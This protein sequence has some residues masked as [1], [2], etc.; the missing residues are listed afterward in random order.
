MKKYLLFCLVSCLTLTFLTSCEKEDMDEMEYAETN[1]VSEARFSDTLV[2]EY[3]TAIDAY[4]TQNYPNETIEEVYLLDNG[5][6]EASLTNETELLF[7]ANGQFI[8]E[9]IEDEMDEDEEDEEEV[10]EWPAAIDDYITQNYPDAMIEKVELED[11]G[12]Y[13]VELDNGVEVYF[14][15]DGNFLEEEIEDDEDDDEM[16]EEDEEEMEVTDYP[17]IIDDYI[18]QNYPDATIE[19][20]ELEDDGS[21]EVELDNGVELYFDADGNFLK[22]G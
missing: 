20:I 2:T 11:D 6:Y 19:E 7:D 17:S 9:I 1:Q 21:Y 14:D 12:S 4:I 16:E 15:A 13:E 5:N 8:E 3:P 22:E 18:T 10:T